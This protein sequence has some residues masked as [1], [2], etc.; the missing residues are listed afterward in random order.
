M[1]YGVVSDREGNVADEVWKESFHALNS[2]N[3]KKY[4][5]LRAFHSLLKIILCFFGVPYL[6]MGRS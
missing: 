1:E 6:G 4:R 5:V 3:F 2:L